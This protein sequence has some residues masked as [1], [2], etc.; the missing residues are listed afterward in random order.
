MI[1]TPENT[2]NAGNPVRVF[3]DGVEQSQCVMA[4]TE[5]GVVEIARPD[6]YVGGDEI[7]T[8]TVSGKVTVE[9]YNG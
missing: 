4:D 6:L 3:V 7:P 9:P 2:S 1:Y 5:K 8:V